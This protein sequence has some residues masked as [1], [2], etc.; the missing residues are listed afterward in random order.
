MTGKGS[1]SP[2]RGRDLGASKQGG[3]KESKL[4]NDTGGG[5]SMKKKKVTLLDMTRANNISIVLAR[6]DDVSFT[7]LT[8]AV[9]SLDTMGMSSEHLRYEKTTFQ[10]PAAAAVS[11]VT[12]PTHPNPFFVSPF[13]VSSFL[14]RPLLFLWSQTF[15]P[16]QIIVGVGPDDH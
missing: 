5:R 4:K 7:K 9:C 1:G 8:R 3:R 10:G 12:D 15:S 16:G 13:L 6:F 11:Q 2:G 14:T